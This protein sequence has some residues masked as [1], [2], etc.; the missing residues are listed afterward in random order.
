M[1]DFKYS[2]K[3]SLSTL[4]YINAESK[5]VLLACPHRLLILS[6]P[7]VSQ[8]QGTK[9]VA[10]GAFVCMHIVAPISRCSPACLLLPCETWS[11][12]GTQAHSHVLPMAG[13]RHRATR[14]AALGPQILEA[15]TPT[16]YDIANIES[17]KV[18]LAR[19]TCL[20]WRFFICQFDWFIIIMFP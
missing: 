9:A 12:S 11:W 3:I 6:R 5:D 19:T 7:I 14:A 20:L 18:K 16:V 2:E 1:R 15:P 10:K 17:F 4:P 13:S 8:Q